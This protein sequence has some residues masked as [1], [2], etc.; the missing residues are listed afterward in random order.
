MEKCKNSCQAEWLTDLTV[1]LLKGVDR[2]DYC[3]CKHTGLA[4]VGLGLE[5]LRQIGAKN[6]DIASLLREY[7]IQ[8]DS[9]TITKA[10]K[11]VN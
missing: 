2:K 1:G 6:T 4:L 11:Y 9:E 5:A 7:A 10:N 3:M 8:I